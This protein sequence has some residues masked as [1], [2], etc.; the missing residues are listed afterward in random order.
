M[1]LDRDRLREAVQTA[2]VFIYD[3]LYEASFPRTQQE[4]LEDFEKVL[5]TN[6]VSTFVHLDLRNTKMDDLQLR[7]DLRR[8]KVLAISAKFTKKK[9]SLNQALRLI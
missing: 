2:L 3:F 7:V 6:R 5:E 1:D 4:V 8:R 9:N